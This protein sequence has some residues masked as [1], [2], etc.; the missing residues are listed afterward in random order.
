VIDGVA[1]RAIR[2]PLRWIGVNPLTEQR[3]PAAVRCGEA[4]HTTSVPS[5]PSRGADRR[6]L[7]N[8]LVSTAGS[9]V[10]H[11]C[12]LAVI[13]SRETGVRTTTFSRRSAG[14]A[15]RNVAAAAVERQRKLYL[16]ST[17]PGYAVRWSFVTSLHLVLT[18]LHLVLSAISAVGILLFIS[19]Q[20]V[21]L[22]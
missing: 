10:V 13:S 22:S 9:V 2:P 1:C 4:R 6:L 20:N 21:I 11:E 15:K 5:S 8:F 14:G 17:A 3:R 7:S 19:A 12:P 18:S 16:H